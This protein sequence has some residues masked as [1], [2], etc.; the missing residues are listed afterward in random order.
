MVSA[1]KHLMVSVFL[2]VAAASAWAQAKTG[3]Q[4]REILEIFD[5]HPRLPIRLTDLMH[6]NSKIAPQ[7]V[8]VFLQD[9][10]FLRGMDFRP[11]DFNHGWRFNGT[12]SGV[13]NDQ[14]GWLLGYPDSPFRFVRSGPGVWKE[15]YQTGK[16][17]YLQ[18]NPD[19]VPR[20]RI[21]LISDQQSGMRMHFFIP[22]EQ[23]TASV[24]PFSILVSGAV[25]TL[26]SDPQCSSNFS[27]LPWTGKPPSKLYLNDERYTEGTPGICLVFY[28]ISASAPNIRMSSDR[29]KQAL[30]EGCPPVDWG[31]AGYYYT[32]VGD[33]IPGMWTRQK[34]LAKNYLRMNQWE[35]VGWDEK[36]L[37]R[38]NCEGLRW[39]EKPFN[40][41]FYNSVKIEYAKYPVTIE[42]SPDQRKPLDLRVPLAAGSNEAYAVWFMLTNDSFWLDYDRKNMYWKIKNEK[43]R[44]EFRMWKANP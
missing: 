36:Y 10:L 29:N 23:T 41:F 33:A 39:E 3:A 32:H 18:C 21:A 24:P 8:P 44:S 11:V 25:R 42:T 38:L 20:V 2:L 16:D 4:V 9:A 34:D 12:E 13:S 7:E 43:T 19:A 1:K 30:A 37:Y 40:T 14:A 15:V 5:L 6:N 35:A 22:F 26:P 17:T 27:T 31:Y 28:P